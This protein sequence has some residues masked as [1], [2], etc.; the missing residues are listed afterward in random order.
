[1]VTSSVGQA[2]KTEHPELQREKESMA[3]GLAASSRKG[4]QT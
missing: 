3:A 2:M 4:R 1:M